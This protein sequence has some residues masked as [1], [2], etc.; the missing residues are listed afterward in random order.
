MTV[1]PL[2][3]ALYVHAASLPAS[4]NHYVLWLD[5]MGVQ[6]IMARSL[7]ISANFIFKF[8]S[9]A[10]VTKPAG[11]E[12]YPVMDG[13]YAVS[14][15]QVD[16]KQFMRDVLETLA[17]LFIDAAQDKHRF[18]V[19]GG[20]A[21]G[22]LIRGSALVAACAPTLAQQPAYAGTLLL[23]MPVIQAHLGEREAPPFGIFVNESARAFAPASTFPFNEIWWS[24]FDPTHHQ[25]AVTLRTA[26][27]TYLDWCTS[28]AGPIAYEPAR[29]VAHR[30]MVQQY[31]PT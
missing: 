18:V 1:N 5:V 24:W 28:H 3:D 30:A 26:L 15:N 10:L 20:L 19:R 9:A 4:A 7:P 29:I 11:V 27:L 12:L 13:L 22:P 16:I 31:L 25:L 21:Y 17:R 14:T 8:H 2:P 6:S 23:G